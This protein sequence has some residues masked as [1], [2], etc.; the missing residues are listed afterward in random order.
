[1]GHQGGGGA[2]AQHLPH[3]LAGVGHLVEDVEGER[4]GVI[5][6]HFLLLGTDLGQDLGVLG[7]EVAHPGEG[8]RGGILGGEQEVENSRADLVVGRVGWARDALGVVRF[9]LGLLPFVKAQVGIGHPEV[10]QAHRLNIAILG[11]FLH[12]YFTIFMKGKKN[13]KVKIIIELGNK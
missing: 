3:D 6:A 8:G 11:C 10:Q 13:V 1:M 5:G 12:C 2:D 9:A 4:R 7:K